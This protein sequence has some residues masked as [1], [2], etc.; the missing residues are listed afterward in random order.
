MSH[1]HDTSITFE[2]DGVRKNNKEINNL[3][4]SEVHFVHVQLNP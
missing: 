3:L 4:Q 2:I 1:F